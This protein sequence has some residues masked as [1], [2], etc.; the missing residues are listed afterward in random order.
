MS[1]ITDRN[2]FQYP[3]KMKI[4]FTVIFWILLQAGFAFSQSVDSTIKEIQSKQKI[5]RENYERYDT[6]KIAIMD[7]S[8]EGGDGIGYYDGEELK[9]IEVNWYGETGKR[10]IE[11][12]FDNGKLMFAFN[13]DFIY[14]RPIYWDAGL[15]KELGDDEVFD[16][17]KTVIEEDRYYF[18]DDKLFQWLDNDN[19]A[20]DLTKINSKVE[21]E[22]VSHAYE[23]KAKFKK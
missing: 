12:Y 14:N 17:Q 7:E 23:M 5:I 4:A 6:V 8:T 13:R 21:R 20:V 10:T 18:K 15:A 2:E 19:K 22:I 9:F 16:S 3:A 1:L 11:Y